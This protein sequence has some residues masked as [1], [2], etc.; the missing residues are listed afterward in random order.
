M[1]RQEYTSVPAARSDVPDPR[2]PRGQRSPW[3]VLLTLI[4]AALASGQRRLRASGQGV[5]EQADDLSAALDPPRGRLP[6]PSTRRRAIQAVAVAALETRVATF[7]ARLPPPARRARW[8]GQALDGQAVRGANRHGAQVHLVSLMRQSD[9]QVLGQ[10]A[11]AE[12]SPALTAAP[13][14]LAGRALTGTVTT[15]D[16]HLPQRRLAQPIREQ[17]GPSVMIVTTNP[18]ERDGAMDRLVPAPLIADATDDADTVTTMGKG[19][20]RLETRPVERRAALN[21]W[22]DWPSVGQ[23]LRRPCRRLILT[24][25]AVQDEVTDGVTRRPPTAA[26]AA[27]VETRW[28]GH[29][30]IENRGHS[31]RAVTVGEDAG[32]QRVGS[33]PQA[34]AARR[35]GRLSLLRAL[36]WTN[37][38][39]ALRHDGAYAHRALH[40]L[41]TSPARL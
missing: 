40:L 19:H 12:Q 22:L 7:V 13:R 3:P 11:V 28:R 14:L 29:G 15:M 17:G 31:G 30:T 24:T 32:Q 33:T 2:Q 34:L 20:G 8:D 10:V 27:Q 35:Q 23:V 41:S 26:T 21:P 4:A 6:R 36:G 25:G 5:S 1:D 38:A 37:S 9:G 39:D 16:A 18:P